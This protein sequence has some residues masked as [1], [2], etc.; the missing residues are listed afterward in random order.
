MYQEKEKWFK[1]EARTDPFSKKLATI[2]VSSNFGKLHFISGS[3]RGQL[4]A[5]VGLGGRGR[6]PS[7]RSDR[8][9][10]IR[11]AEHLSGLGSGRPRRTGSQPFDHHQGEVRNGPEVTARRIGPPL[12]E[13]TP[14]TSRPAA[15]LAAA[16]GPDSGR[17]PET[18]IS[19][20][21]G[22]ESGPGVSAGGPDPPH[23]DRAPPP[24]PPPEYPAQPG[25][26]IPADPRSQDLLLS[27]KNDPRGLCC[28]TQCS[29]RKENVSSSQS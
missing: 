27:L 22:R 3:R 23:Y 28:K 6:K 25:H 4:R 24:P 20:R 2:R 7:L 18:G 15:V 13:T 12:P 16:T 17:R 1:K 11:R 8:F 5:G 29:G 21:R 19:A 26:W 14:E 10:R 9:R